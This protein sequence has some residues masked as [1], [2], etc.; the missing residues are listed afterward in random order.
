MVKS[1]DHDG[2]WYTIGIPRI[3][4]YTKKYTK[5]VYKWYTNGIPMVYQIGHGILDGKAMVYHVGHTGI[6]NETWYTRW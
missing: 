6:P 4:W 2:T 1:D 5:M 3:R